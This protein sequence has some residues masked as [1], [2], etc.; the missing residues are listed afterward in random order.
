MGG[1]RTFLVAAAVAVTVAL[2][3]GACAGTD[4]GDGLR[5]VA[6][7]YPLAEAASRVGGDRVDVANLTPGGS[8]PHDFELTTR[9]VDRV[10]DADLVVYLGGGFQPAIEA[11][12]TRSPARAVDL[13][14]ADLDLL[15]GHD[16]EHGDDE[17]GDG[18]DAVSDPHVWL[19]PT[20]MAAMVGTIRDELTELDPAGRAD[21][22][23]NADAYTTELAALDAAFG[24]GLARCEQRTF[25]TAHEAFGYLARRY[26]L[27]EQ[28]IAGLSP[29]AEPDPQ[30]L[31]E[32]IDQVKAEGITTVFTETLVSPRV[33]ETLAREAGVEVAVLNPVEGRTDDERSR[34]E[35]YVSLMEDNLAAL[36]DALR[37]E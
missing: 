33:A 10:E 4:D 31:A 24:D 7:F 17:H 5:V 13:L 12:V 6:S 14:S 23:A 27:T 25:V 16:D 1:V 15:E 36:R 26:D 20:L 3:G 30:R 28:A 11:A 29:E 37:C 9:D 22:A 21:Y 35:T 34:G 32:L 19:D 18:D 2:A 8:E